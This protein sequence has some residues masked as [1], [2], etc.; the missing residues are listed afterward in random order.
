MKVEL[1]TKTMSIGVLEVYFANYS[2]LLPLF[3]I[4]CNVNISERLFYIL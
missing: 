4:F 2:I 1:K 3:R